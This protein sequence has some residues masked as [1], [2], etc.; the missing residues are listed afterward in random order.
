LKHKIVDASAKRAPTLPSFDDECR[1]D[2]LDALFDETALR[3]RRRTRAIGIAVVG[4]TVFEVMQLSRET[5][6]NTA[7]IFVMREVMERNRGICGN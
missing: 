4:A 5:A 6:T 2:D 7:R 1:I 3:I